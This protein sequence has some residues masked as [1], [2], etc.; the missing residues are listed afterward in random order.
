MNISKARADEIFELLRMSAEELLTRYGISIK[1]G[2]NSFLNLSSCPWC[3]YKGDK[4]GS[5]ECGIREIPG[6]RGYLHSV[7]CMH[8]HR[9][10][11]GDATP[12][13]ADFLVE[14]GALTRDEAD[15]VKERRRT[16]AVAPRPAGTHKPVAAV[17]AVQ[18]VGET[19]APRADDGAL[20]LMNEENNAKNRRR[21]RDNAPAMEYLQKTRGFG[22]RT[23]ERFKLGLSAPYIK[24]DVLVHSNALTAPLVGF[25]GRFYKKYV[26]YAVPGV[27][28]DNRD[29]PQRAWSPGSA[30]AYYSGDSREKRWI[31]I[32]DGLKD[33]WALSQLLEGSD[34]D[35]QITFASS[36]N[37]GQG[38]PAEWKDPAFWQRYEHV[39]LGHDNDQ[40]NALTG[41]R[42]GD[43]HALALAEHIGR[44]TRR[45][46]PP[47]VKDWN[48]WTLAGNTLEAFRRL[49]EG[50]EAL[51]V[52][53]VIEDHDDGSQQGRFAAN[54][55]QIVGAFNSGY[56]YEAVRTMVRD[57]DPET[58]ELG[59]R[60]DTLVV[61]SDRTVHRV[62]LMPAPRGTPDSQIVRRLFPD[63]TMITASPEPNPNLTWSWAS[64]QAWLKSTDRTPSLKYILERIENHL[65][66]C[67]WLPYSDD[68]SI[69]ACCVAA[70]YVQQVFDAVPLIL[71]TG[72]AGTGKSELGLALKSLG[73]NSKNVLGV[74][75]PATLARFID[76]TRGMVVIDDLEDI[77]NSKDTTFGDVVQTLKLSYKKSTA[78]KLVT[79]M[80]N[81]KAIQRQFN[82]FG[83]KIINNTRGADAIL[84]TRML[85]I[86]TRHM[87]KGMSLQRD[88]TLTPD[89]LDTLRD[90]LH[91]WAFTNV[92]AVDQSYQAIFPNKSGRQEEISA[93]LR[94]IAALSGN[95]ALQASLE[96]ALERQVRVKQ[97]PDSPEDL[98]RESLVNIIQRS[99]ERDGEVPTWVTVTQ[100]MM[101]MRTLV[102][103]NYGKEFTTSLA[104]IEKPEWVGR[105]LRQV[106]AEDP[107]MLS[108]RTNMYG[109]GLRA[110]QLSTEYLNTVMKQLTADAPQLFKG[111]LPHSKNFKAFCNGCGA[112]RY[113]S[114]CDMQAERE[115]TELR[116]SNKNA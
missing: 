5:F 78:M 74:V 10:A 102:D 76:A 79:E 49:L 110:Y 7:K 52:E 23:I 73:A 69:L 83:I 37:G 72:A 43:E 95:A 90:Q 51:Q 109:K 89:H 70:S 59:E 31:F 104:Q 86:Q 13:Y 21:L 65:R 77:A 94:V 92:M 4:D 97:D 9:S 55:I 46:T 50:S 62:K 82:F 24:D 68:F 91:C 96:R 80:K 19:V 8:P 57:P 93:P 116:P 39:F 44:P 112:C 101:E 17:S 40:P 22:Q 85:T 3:N 113:R 30:R 38:V 48:D 108:A 34:L 98:L 36:T 11:T 6:D 26:N 18:P 32:C 66:G 27:T 81:G 15:M 2:N 33:L 42:A 14:L 29:K 1:K 115:K 107:N 61:R 99:I 28:E 35:E 53:E 64:I 103:D 20:V 60:Y 45:V 106:Y 75:S 58:G 111:T 105:T 54:P 41:R 84:T 25:D 87:P 88:L 71:V 47:A 63:G 114:K 100:V 56:L 67:V 12:H 16:G